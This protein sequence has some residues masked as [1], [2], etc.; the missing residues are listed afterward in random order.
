MSKN[1]EINQRQRCKNLA[2]LISRVINE[3]MQEKP[4]EPLDSFWILSALLSVY[5]SLV[6]IPEP[7][8]SAEQAKDNCSHIIDDFW[9]Y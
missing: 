9:G 3:E 8:I 4:S 1:I 2:V 5:Y 7:L 6:T